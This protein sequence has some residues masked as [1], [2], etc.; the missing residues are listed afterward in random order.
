MQ[1]AH[2]GNE[3][4]I[5]RWTIIVNMAIVSTPIRVIPGDTS[6]ASNKFTCHGAQIIASS[7]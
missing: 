3:K 1:L 2:L 5:A 4:L 7:T 6:A